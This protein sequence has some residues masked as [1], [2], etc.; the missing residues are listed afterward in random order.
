M[1]TWPHDRMTTCTEVHAAGVGCFRLTANQ[2]GASAFLRGPSRAGNSQSKKIPPVWITLTHKP[3]RVRTWVAYEWRFSQPST[4][5]LRPQTPHLTFCSPTDR[6]FKSPPTK[7]KSHASNG[8]GLLK[9]RSTHQR[10]AASPTHTT[11]WC[12]AWFY[13]QPHCTNRHV[14]SL[15]FLLTNV[16]IVRCFG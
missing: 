10:S 15:L 11:G 2:N 4:S 12:L 3:V 1:I 6:M 5:R 9:V 13:E 7:Q 14:Q 8:R 16:L